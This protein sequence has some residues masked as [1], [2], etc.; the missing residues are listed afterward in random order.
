MREQPTGIETI[1]AEVVEEGEI[2]E[3]GNPEAR[4]KI[5]RALAERPSDFSDLDISIAELDI[6]PTKLIAELSTLSL[7][8]ASYSEEEKMEL[9]KNIVRLLKV[10]EI[11]AKTQDNPKK[12]RILH[13]LFAFIPT[14]REFIRL[15]KSGEKDQKQ[16]VVV[17]IELV[18]G[19]KLL[20]KDLNIDVTK[21][22]PEL[23]EEEIEKKERREQ[24]ELYLEK[25]EGYLADSAIASG[26]RVSTSM[27]YWDKNHILSGDYTTEKLA[28]ASSI[29]MKTTKD[30]KLRKQ[31]I[32]L[33]DSV[34]SNKDFDIQDT[35]I[36]S[37]G[38]SKETNFIRYWDISNF[39]QILKNLK[40]EYT[41][42]LESLRG[43]GE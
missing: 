17:R 41:K 43:K 13:R 22:I 40:L 21:A 33:L 10:L 37:S 26:F 14:V 32:G 18:A 11:N 29:L 12:V 39:T 5:E 15:Q 7:D 8:L 23:E 36:V 24:L 28:E 30:F 27:G 35:K 2:V 9:L 20:A 3:M 1:S 34:G 16:R 42:E 25:I 4:A 38:L 19:A 31:L 6:N